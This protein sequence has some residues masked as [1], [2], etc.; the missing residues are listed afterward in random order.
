M[1]I[2]LGTTVAAIETIH[3]QGPLQYTG[4]RTDI[5]VQGDGYFVLNDGT[6]N[7]YSR[8]GNFVLDGNGN[9]VQSGTGYTL[10]GYELTVDPDNP[11]RYIRGTRLVSLNIPVGQKLSAK[12]T[13]VLGLQCNLDSRVNTYLPMGL[14]NSNFSTIANIGGQNYEIS[15]AEGSGNNLLSISIGGTA[16]GL[17]LDGIN[18]TTGLPELSSAP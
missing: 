4:N 5:A 16:Y 13:E 12:E 6:R 3:S 14:T 8:A 17:T 18:T 2:G 1:Q 11:S 7:V 10:M 9:I 15:I